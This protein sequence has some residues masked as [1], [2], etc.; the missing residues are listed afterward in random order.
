[1]MC[2]IH[3]C[4]TKTI[5]A[6]VSK[7]TGQPY[8]AF[9]IC[10]IKDCT[11]KPGQNPNY[12]N[13]PP[14]TPQYA[15][16]VDPQTPFKENREEYGRRLAIHGMVNGMLAAGIAPHLI[17]LQNLIQLEDRINDTLD[18]KIDDYSQDIDVSDIPF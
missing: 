9:E 7:R 3:N 1:M 16:P 10:Q 12:P 13:N 17:P 2:P 6:G 11:W 8:N 15:P 14:K 5:P 4:E 18:G